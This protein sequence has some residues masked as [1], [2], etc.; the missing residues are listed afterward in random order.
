LE[1]RDIRQ[2]PYPFGQFLQSWLATRGDLKPSSYA[3]YEK[4]AECWVIPHLGNFALKDLRPSHFVEMTAKLRK[5]GGRRGGALSERS[6]QYAMSVARI[7]L[8]AAVEEG[9]IATNPVAAVP[10]TARPKPRP[11]E[12]KTWTAAEASAFLRHEKATATSR[13]GQ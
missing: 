4:T 1:A 5:D 8:T 12:M 7:A 9:L 13:C 10:R 2:R 3:G 11:K 6:I